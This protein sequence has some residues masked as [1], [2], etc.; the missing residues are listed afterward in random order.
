MDGQDTTW[1]LPELR[2]VIAVQDQLRGESF[3][4]TFPELQGLIEPEPPS[5][6]VP[7]ASHSSAAG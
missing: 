5:G 2:R 1:A 7:P 4:A 3:T 6:A